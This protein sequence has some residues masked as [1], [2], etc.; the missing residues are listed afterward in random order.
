LANPTAGVG[1]VESNTI[2]RIGSISKLFTVYMYLITASDASFND[3]IT[4]YVPEL[5]QYAQSQAGVLETDD[6]DTVIWNNITI[7]ALASHP[8]GIGRDASFAPIFEQ[9]YLSFGLPPVPLSNAS[10]CGTSLVPFPSDR[11]GKRCPAFHGLF[12]GRFH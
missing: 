6:I 9:S 8:A 12:H 2:Y 3:P 5:A 11:A 10:Y 1:T 7:G 4:K